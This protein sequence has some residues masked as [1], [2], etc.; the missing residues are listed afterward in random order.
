[1]SKLIRVPIQQYVFLRRSLASKNNTIDKLHY[2]IQLLK[3]E[4]VKLQSQVKNM[5]SMSPQQIQD[6]TI[7]YFRK[8]EA[9]FRTNFGCSFKQFDEIF[10]KLLPGFKSITQN[11][12][13]HQRLAR[14]KPLHSDKFQLMIFLFWLKRYYEEH[15]IARLFNITPR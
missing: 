15:I 10:F 2:N 9:T 5:G 12:N 8:S 3:Q 4:I 6:E 11:G 13:Q 1:M 14:Q 7:L